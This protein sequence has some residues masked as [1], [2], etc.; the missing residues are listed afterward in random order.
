MINTYCS[1]I[2]P[3]ELDHLLAP[4]IIMFHQKK[5]WS[6]FPTHAKKSYKFLLKRK[7]VNGTRR[8]TLKSHSV[9]CAT[10]GP[11]FFPGGPLSILTYIQ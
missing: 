5:Q 7:T 6:D 8:I 9:S 1:V 3:V 10:P 4:F 2:T 11:S